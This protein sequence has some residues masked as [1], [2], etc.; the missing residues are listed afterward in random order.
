MGSG[1]SLA[2]L[3]HIKPSAISGS[4]QAQCSHLYNGGMSALPHGKAMRVSR[5]VPP[6]CYG[7]SSLCP[8]DSNFLCFLLHSGRFTGLLG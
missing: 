8:A 1:E 4:S 5:G 3:S 6:A 7:E 2:Q